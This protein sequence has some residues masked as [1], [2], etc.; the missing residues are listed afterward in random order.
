LGAVSL[1]TMA[2]FGGLRLVLVSTAVWI[3]SG[4]GAGAGRI[5]RIRRRP[6]GVFQ[7][8]MGTP[9]TVR[10]VSSVVSGKVLPA[11]ALP[12]STSAASAPSP[13]ASARESVGR[14]VSQ[15]A[16][17]WRVGDRRERF[18]RWKLRAPDCRRLQPDRQGGYR[19]R[20]AGDSPGRAQTAGFGDRDAARD[21]ER[22]TRDGG[23]GSGYSRD[24]PTRWRAHPGSTNLDADSA[25]S[26][27]LSLRP[28]ELA[29]PAGIGG[30]PVAENPCM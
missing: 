17:R 19:Q 12:F 4:L 13:P 21:D 22:A 27:A 10:S 9:S 20:C 3:R 16:V 14:G 30:A 11:A 8:R 1:R 6:A 2:L 28:F 15:R 25:R 5:L 23:R 29:T 26:S 24:R 7:L 18:A